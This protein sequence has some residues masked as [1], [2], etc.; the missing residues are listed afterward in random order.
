M[1]GVKQVSDL[2][3]LLKRKFSAIPLFMALS[4][5][6]LGCHKSTK[7]GPADAAVAYG[8]PVSSPLKYY[9]HWGFN[10]VYTLPVDVGGQSIEAVLDTGSANL[11]VI[12]D[13]SICPNC[14]NEYG[15]TSVY[16]QSASGKF[17]DYSW[18]MSFL[19]LGKATVSGFQDR[20]SFAGVNLSQYQLGLVTAEQG[21]PN[22]WGIG[23]RDSARPA[24]SPQTPLFDALASAAHWR[25]QFSLRLCGL[26]VGSNIT[27]GG[28]DSVLSTRL[29][30]VQWTPIVDRSQYGIIAKRVYVNGSGNST[31]PEW[32]WTPE[33]GE[34][35]LVDSGTNP[36]V[37]PSLTVSKLIALLKDVAIK[38]GISLPDDFWPG[39]SGPGGYA[40]LSP[41]NIGKFPDILL[42]L[43][44]YGDTKKVFT[45]KITPQYYFQTRDD[46]KQFLGIE[47]GDEVN[48][49]GTVFMENYLVL[50]DRGSIDSS[51]Y[52]DP[53][54]R[55]GFLPIAGLCR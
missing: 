11:L 6:A 30:E 42:D 19:P 34:T 55:V 28:F 40:N 39:S 43:E 18:G 17:L 25:N 54:A 9:N 23:Y 33:F 36:I 35:L 51:A 24:A 45:L 12:G 4:L 22:I 3:N 29:S 10:Q 41:S 5:T 44:E 20:V 26:K 15:Y 32:S 37:L 14:K 48:I 31:N 13:Q 50:F 52:V 53:T 16:K 7:E 8:D 1:V 2:V 21:I 47:A 38:N 49:L 46:G 27:L